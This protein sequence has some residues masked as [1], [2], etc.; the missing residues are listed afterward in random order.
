ML[1][2]TTHGLCLNPPLCLCEQQPP[3][4]QLAAAAESREAAAGKQGVFVPR[5]SVEEEVSDLDLY[6]GYALTLYMARMSGQTR[7][8]QSRSVM[9]ALHGAEE[10]RAVFML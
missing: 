4:P 1:C 2:L 6:I 10:A 3:P 5:R 8:L 9:P 7:Y